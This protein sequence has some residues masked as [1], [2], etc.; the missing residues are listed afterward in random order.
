MIS[1]RTL[2][3]IVIAVWLIIASLYLIHTPLDH[4]NHDYGHHL[5]YTEIISKEHS[6]LKPYDGTETYQP[7]LYYLVNSFIAP[8]SIK[9]DKISHSNYVRVLSVVYGSITIFLLFCL[10]KE[11]FYNPV[12]CLFPLLF[13]ITTPKFVFVFSTYNND[14]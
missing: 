4:R 12:F 5:F 6:F 10:L 13:L 14:S 3:E 2:L 11:A 1:N 9:S 8:E 7:P